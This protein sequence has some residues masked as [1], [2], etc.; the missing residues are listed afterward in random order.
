[1][2]QWIPSFH[3][4]N[5]ILAIHTACRA[6][7]VTLRHAVYENTVKISLLQNSSDSGKTEWVHEVFSG[8]L[9]GR[10]ELSHASFKFVT[11]YTWLPSFHCSIC[12][13][14]GFLFTNCVH[15]GRFLEKIQRPKRHQDEHIQSVLVPCAATAA[16]EAGAPVAAA[17][18]ARWSRVALRVL[19]RLPANPT[20]QS[21]NG[22]RQTRTDWR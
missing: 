1:M 22:F 11:L 6:P 19:A 10:S 21:N 20:A 5:S 15:L 13:Y 17:A 16:P 4:T 3:P 9:E 14:F 18:A 7:F 8:R 2:H 12:P